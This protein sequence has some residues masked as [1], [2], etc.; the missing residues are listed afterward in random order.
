MTARDVALSLGVSQ[1]TVSRA[2][3]PGSPVS[4]ALRERI[5]A[6]A[7]DLGY[8]PNAFARS[9]TMG[10]SN[11]VAMMISRRTNLLYPELLY[12]LTEKL[13]ERGHHLMLFT[14]EGART[15]DQ[16]VDQIWSQ[17]VDAV[18]ST[19]VADRKLTA[20]FVAGACRSCCL[21][22][23]PPAT[24]RGCSPTIVR[25][26]A[27]GRG[28]VGERAP[29]L[30]RRS[31]PARLVHRGGSG[32]RRRAGALRRGRCERG[33]GAPPPLNTAVRPQPSPNSSSG[34]AGCPTR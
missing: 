14:T 5:A 12:A 10:R 3:K 2:F 25:V 20:Q 23:R 1:A 4:P 9:L 26:G 24:S 16:V 28:P 33:G 19:H 11:I 13:S 7:R 17:R 29:P 31:G 32:G 27:A 15:L 34:R 22:V 6:A 8:Q 30:R 21:I 18:F